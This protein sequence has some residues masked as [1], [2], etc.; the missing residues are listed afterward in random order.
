VG[1]L[2]AFLITLALTLEPFVA[3]RANRISAAYPLELAEVFA[4]WQGTA[5][6]VAGAVS[7]IVASLRSPSIWRLSVGA[8][9][10]LGLSI[11]IGA[12]PQRLISTSDSFA[13]VAPAGGAWLLF[14]A[15]AVVVLDAMTKLAF[16][17]VKRLLALAVTLGVFA[18]LLRSGQWDGLSVMQ[19]Y[20]ARTDTFW[21]EV[22]RHIALVATSVIA[23]VIVGVPLGI[24]S[25]NTPGLGSILLPILSIVQTIPSIAMYGLLM[26]PLALIAT[27]VPFAAELG[28]RGIGV[29]PAALAL[30]LYSLLPITS[31]V[32]LGLRQISRQAVEAALAVG[33]TRWQRLVQV[34]LPLAMP[35]IINGVRIVLVQNIGLAAVAAL[36]GAG[37][38]GVFIFQGL[39]QSADDLVLLGTIPTIVLALVASVVFE[40]A[41]SM[42]KGGRE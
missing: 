31:N 10:L 32:V 4:G 7:A 26:A 41:T 6:Y 27:H 23:A 35:V 39:G 16:G 28:V 20:A 19:E 5:L 37:G 3:F 21:L 11:V 12:L 1:V 38:L 33:M 25:V 9:L 22:T 14:L 18:A 42:A 40:V 24:A 17:P 13:R 36:I 29:A 30:W 2:V 8:I 15:Y 34:E